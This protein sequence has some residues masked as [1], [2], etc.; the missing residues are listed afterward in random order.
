MTGTRKASTGYKAV[1]FAPDGDWVTDCKGDT[2]EEVYEA[3]G[4]LGSRW[5]FYPYSHFIIRDNGAYTTSRQR[6]VAACEP[7]E[8]L[9]GR[10]ISTVSRFLNEQDDSFHEAVL[11]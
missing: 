6:I 9:Q 7:L 11:S 3:L 10:A 2:L 1:L 4:D 5:Y 8:F